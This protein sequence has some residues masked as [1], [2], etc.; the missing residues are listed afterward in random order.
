[1]HC[2]VWYSVPGLAVS[3]S[4]YNDYYEQC[5]FYGGPHHYPGYMYGYQDYATQGR[6]PFGEPLPDQEQGGVDEPE[7]IQFDDSEEAASDLEGES[8]PSG[9]ELAT[10]TTPV[11]CKLFTNYA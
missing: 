6:G 5:S 8:Q 2:T 1:M 7:S 9:A 4:D 10:S 11:F 3:M